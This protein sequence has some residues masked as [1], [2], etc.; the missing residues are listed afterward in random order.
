M[1]VGSDRAAT[2]RAKAASNACATDA[3]QWSGEYKHHSEISVGTAAAAL[4]P[5]WARQGQPNVEG[6]CAGM[7]FSRYDTEQRYLRT[8]RVIAHERVNAVNRNVTR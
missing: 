2:D 6:A 1:P 7:S 3:C 5:G 8:A 4:D